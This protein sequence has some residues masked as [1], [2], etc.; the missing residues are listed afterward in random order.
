[1]ERRGEK[2]RWAYC[3]YTAAIKL[4]GVAL[5]V[6]LLFLLFLRTS[7]SCYFPII[8]NVAEWLGELF[9]TA[10]I[11]E[12]SKITIVTTL[13]PTWLFN[14]FDKNCWGLKCG[15][16]VMAVYPNY[17]KVLVSHFLCTALCTWMA[18]SGFREPAILALLL[19]VLCVIL[20]LKILV[21]II[22]DSENQDQIALD[23]WRDRLKAPMKLTPADFRG[24]LCEYIGVVAQ[25]ETYRMDAYEIVMKAFFHYT[26][27]LGG[28]SENLWQKAGND[29]IASVASI[30]E[31]MES[32]F[33]ERWHEKLKYG[34]TGQLQRDTEHEEQVS[35]VCVGCVF[36][37]LGYHQG[38]IGIETEEKNQKVITSVARDISRIISIGSVRDQDDIALHYLRLAYSTIAQIQARHG[39]IQIGKDI[40]AYLPG[41]P[42]KY[43][44]EI[45]SVLVNHLEYKA[46]EVEETAKK[47]WSTI[48]PE[49]DTQTSVEDTP[50]AAEAVA[51]I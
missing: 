27:M 51:Q 23:I 4:C 1:M 13:F 18:C 14:A 21:R 20:E 5:I 9:P 26:E 48:Y 38:K 22:F 3:I 46:E 34:I 40:F 43:D 24:L 35:I 41:K 25:T 36:W 30:W 2:R 6:S 29:L 19:Q 7:I 33:G 45:I 17:R 50:Q 44:K 47:I 8:S 10:A 37:L 15:Q 16:L 28:D 12:M 31:C 11:V 39:E 49:A 42:E 32:C